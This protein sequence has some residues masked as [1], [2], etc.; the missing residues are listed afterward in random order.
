MQN[1]NN[2]NKQKLIDEVLKMSN[3]KADKKAVSNGDM[4]GLI[5]SLPEA[6]RKKLLDAL[7]SAEKTK[8][9]LSSPAAEKILKAFTD[10]NYNG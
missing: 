10:G 1:Y 6:D 4:D 3:L 9:I 8:K 2:I 7:G 5:A